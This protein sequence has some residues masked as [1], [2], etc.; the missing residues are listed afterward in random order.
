MS[1]AAFHLGSKGSELNGFKIL[2]FYS[3]TGFLS[4]LDVQCELCGA[5][6]CKMTEFA[7]RMITKKEN[8]NIYVKY[9]Q[10]ERRT[11]M[12]GSRYSFFIYS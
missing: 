2:V 7:F 5:Y 3:S 1:Y 12:N 9:K 8:D 10:L 11:H 4:S 6:E